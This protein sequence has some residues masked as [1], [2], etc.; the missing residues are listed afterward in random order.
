V[1]RSVKLAVCMIL[2]LSMIL[3]AGCSQPAG[4]AES[5]GTERVFVTISTG[6]T[7]GS[8]YPLGGTMAKIWTDHIPNVQSSVQSTGGTIQ[9]IQLMADGQTEVGFTDTKY[10]SAYA[11]KGD[12]EGNPQTWMRGMVPLYPEPTNIVVAKGSGITSLADLKGKRVSIGAVGSGTEA[13]SREILAVL[14]ID[15]DSDITAYMLG[16]G[17][18]ASAFQ[19]RQI[20]AAI[21]VGSLGMSSIIELTSLDLVNFLDVPDDIFEAVFDVNNTWIRFDIPAN[22]YQNQ[23]NPVKTYAGFN[24]ISVH[25]N[26]PEDLVYEMTKLLFENKEELVEVRSTMESMSFENV[27]HISLPIHPGSARYYEENGVDMP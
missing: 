17:D 14:G 24:I 19:D 5:S 10:V 26:V 6:T 22:Y 27:H 3:M 7:G 23:P 13:T 15:A 11:G 9:N 25:E 21:L 16:T 4:P 1:S 8:Y 20:D 12:W 2:L 18:T